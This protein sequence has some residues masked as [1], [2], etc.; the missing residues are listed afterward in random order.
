M[1]LFQNWCMSGTRLAGPQTVGNHVRC[2][3][4]QQTGNHP[5]RHRSDSGPTGHHPRRRTHHHRME[6]TPTPSHNNPTSP[7]SNP[8]H[9]SLLPRRMRCKGL[10]HPCVRGRVIQIGSGQEMI[11]V[12]TKGIKRVYRGPDTFLNPTP[13]PSRAGVANEISF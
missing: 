4:L 10:F 3:N 11:G 7:Q 8:S 12:P 6:S 13:S 1:Q 9:P 2:G 5:A